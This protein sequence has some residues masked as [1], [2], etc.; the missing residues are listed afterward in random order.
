MLL[1]VPLSMD[2]SPFSLFLHAVLLPLD[3][4]LRVR[5]CCSASCRE[6]WAGSM[7]R[8]S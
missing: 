2:D 8:D 7:T 3:Y 5:S 6:C 1:Q 4:I